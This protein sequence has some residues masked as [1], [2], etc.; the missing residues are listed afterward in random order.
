MP[1]VNEILK[2]VENDLRD[3]R[4]FYA[5]IQETPSRSLHYLLRYLLRNSGKQLRPALVYLSARSAG[6]V[7]DTTR[8]AATMIELVHNASLIHDD[9]V[10]QAELRRGIPAVYKIWKTKIAV[11]AG[12]YML[13]QGLKLAVDSGHYD[14]LRYMNHAVQAMSMGEIEQLRH[15]RRL[16]LT[17]DGYFDIIRSKTAELLAVCTATGALSAGADPQTVALFHE[18][19]IKLGMAF[20]V[21]DDILDYAPSALFGKIAGNDIQE[22]KLTLPLLYALDSLTP[23]ERKKKLLQ[24][25]R[26]KKKSQERTELL[27]WVRNSDAIERAEQTVRNLTEEAKDALCSVPDSE[28]KNAL[29]ALADYLVARKK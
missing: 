21:R 7:S 22:G 2:P 4:L 20:Q 19:G 25:R 6:E 9:V 13:A 11:L 3:F 5:K 18:F 17:T 16:D 26:A 24:V 8:I 15:A 12:D 14:L 10:D 28:N 23:P 1:S 27:Q 29:F